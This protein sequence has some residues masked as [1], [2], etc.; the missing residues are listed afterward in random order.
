MAKTVKGQTIQNI[1]QDLRRIEA[2]IENITN[3]DFRAKQAL[4][5]KIT[6]PVRE[7]LEFCHNI[8][9]QSTVEGSCWHNWK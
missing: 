5:K 6:K 8:K 9:R 2:R 3:I 1:E 4:H 7:M